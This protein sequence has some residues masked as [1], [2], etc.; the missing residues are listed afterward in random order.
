MHMEEVNFIQFILYF[1]IKIGHLFKMFMPSLSRYLCYIWLLME[2]TNILLRH[3][4][5]PSAI[6]AYMP[7]VGYNSR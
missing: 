1:R 3:F 5:I 7:R 2:Q 4:L 6:H